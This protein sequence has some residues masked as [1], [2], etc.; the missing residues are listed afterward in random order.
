MDDLLTR[1]LVLDWISTIGSVVVN[2]IDSIDKGRYDTP[3][4]LLAHGLGRTIDPST[5]FARACPRS[6]ADCWFQGNGVTLLQVQHG[7]QGV[8]DG[9]TAVLQMMALG[10]PIESFIQIGVDA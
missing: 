8:P 7:P 3:G 2:S 6:R 9:L 10:V 5:G 1:G 4:R